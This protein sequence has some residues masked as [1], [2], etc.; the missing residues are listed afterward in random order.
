M[1][2]LIYLPFYVW[3]IC[4]YLYIASV[5]AF[6]DPRSFVFLIGCVYNLTDT[7]LVTIQ[8]CNSTGGDLHW[9]LVIAAIAASTQSW[10]SYRCLAILMLQ[11]LGITICN[12]HCWLPTSSQW[13]SQQEIGNDDYMT[14]GC[15]NC[16]GFA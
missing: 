2:H 7:S 4:C 10:L 3:H 8:S 14:V 11:C 1:G 15:C 6:G 9:I 13:G 5:L 16:A 12:F